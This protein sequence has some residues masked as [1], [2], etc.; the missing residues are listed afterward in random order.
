MVKV[1]PGWLTVRGK[2]RKVAV[3]D[4]YMSPRNNLVHWHVLDRHFTGGQ[5]SEVISYPFAKSACLLNLVGKPP[6]VPSLVCT[7]KSGASLE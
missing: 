5:G 2:M 6:V 7:Y 1:K 3:I 4:S